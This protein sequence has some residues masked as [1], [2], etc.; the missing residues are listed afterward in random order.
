MA[1]HGQSRGTEGL[2]WSSRLGW[3]L[4]YG[5]D[6]W[7][8]F[9]ASCKW[10]KAGNLPRIFSDY[11]VH[12]GI[13]G[14]AWCRLSEMAEIDRAST[15][16]QLFVGK[17]QEVTDRWLHAESR[18]KAGSSRVQGHSS[19][20]RQQSRRPRHNNVPQLPPPPPPFVSTIGFDLLNITSFTCHCTLPVRHGMNG[21][22]LKRRERTNVNSHMSGDTPHPSWRTISADQSGRTTKSVSVYYPLSNGGHEGLLTA[23]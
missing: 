19:V 6:G 23:N 20:A 22:A 2:E 21:C 10:D 13:K 4:I 12:F 11:P 14:E 8:P 17:G 3:E 9:S 18:I 16:K 1:A 7:M 5:A 15:A